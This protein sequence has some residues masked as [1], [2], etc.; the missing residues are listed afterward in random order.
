[1][2]VW[3]LS[4]AGVSACGLGL[5]VMGKHIETKKLF[6]LAVSA[7]LL[8]APVFLSPVTNFTKN[9][10]WVFVLTF[11]L[12]RI[13]KY[14]FFVCTGA[15]MIGYSFVAILEYLTTFF[16]AVSP[17]WA[18][19]ALLASPGA[20]IGAV[21]AVIGQ[22]LLSQ[23]PAR[24]RF[25]D[26]TRV[27][28]REQLRA[29]K[30]VPLAQLFT[31]FLVVSVLLA[32]AR[33]QMLEFTMFLQVLLGR[34]L[35]FVLVAPILLCAYF[36]ERYFAARRTSVTPL[37]L[38]DFVLIVPVIL[39]VLVYTGGPASPWKVL[40]IPFVI[41]NAL[42]KN[43]AFGIAGIAVAA[44]IL[45]SLNVIQSGYG[46]F[47][48]GLDLVFL[49]SFFFVFVV[50]RSFITAENKLNAEIESARRNLLASISHDLRTPITLLQGY[51]EALLDKVDI[52]P[53]KGARYLQLI[54]NRTNSLKNL[55]RDLAELVQLETR[56]T[57]LNFSRV[58]V[59]ELL[60]QVY[61]HYE[62][63]VSSKGILLKMDS[64]QADGVRIKADPE[65]LDRVFANLIYN[66]IN[67]T[68]AGGVITVGARTDFAADEVLF[69]VSDTGAGVS[70]EE[71]PKIFEKFYRGTGSKHPVKGSGL[72][73]AISKEIVEYHSGRVWAES[74]ENRGS[75]FFF[76]LPITG[77]KVR[78][79]VKQSPVSV[80][81]MGPPAQMISAFIVLVA[82]FSSG[83]CFVPPSPAVPAFLGIAALSLF[84][85]LAARQK[86]D[87]ATTRMGLLWFAADIII[88]APLIFHVIISTGSSSS[89][90][91]VLFIPFIITNTM[92]PEKICG[93]AG[94]A[95][96]TA[97]LLLSG[98]TSL[99][100]GP[101]WFIEQDLAYIS[102]FTVTHV[103]VRHF[104]SVENSLNREL[105]DSRRT[106]LTGV[107]FELQAPMN[108]I[109]ES[110][111]GLMDRGHKEAGERRAA[112]LAV[113]DQ[114][115]R[116]TRMVED[117]FELV[118]LESRRSVLNLMHFP[119]PEL[120]ARVAR[121]HKRKSGD[122]D[123]ALELTVPDGFPADQI[124]IQAD[125]DRLGEVLD[126]LMT[127]AGV[128]DA[129]KIGFTLD[130]T[131]QEVLFRIFKSHYRTAAAS[132]DKRTISASG[133][134]SGRLRFLI[135]EQIIHLHGG[136]FLNHETPDSENGFSFTL[137][138]AT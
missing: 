107:A 103:I 121:K 6:S 85:A 53:E 22:K 47:P 16:V 119:L 118:Q 138:V 28:D 110:V 57:S 15:V 17:T 68:P 83:A 97:A 62:H 72:G 36:T 136:R 95:T 125:P 113:Q 49:V 23:K 39:F 127:A 1:M 37:D 106:L 32:T 18:I 69:Y 24:K 40:L 42:K 14:S 86:K 134:A 76:A 131:G 55:A 93:L 2:L 30:A 129:V 100:T 102:L 115:K 75:S 132:D 122:K 9:Y 64:P 46:A 43:T 116:L 70:K 10:L 38:V 105:A 58:S 52:N 19:R 31:A 92:K 56:K 54:L 112:L 74:E 120:A 27:S 34:F 29:L 88:L 7:S 65:R 73:L 111:G 109:S 87:I 8:T 126:Y 67:H 25:E 94:L 101:G 13:K 20:L 35:I 66:A 80:S 60:G 77:A 99:Q 123:L 50:I 90:W 41:I 130:Y 133:D 81:G 5:F 137:P 84:A 117:L 135:A 61:V 78:E 98:A 108:V 33:P 124:M 59:S 82:F 79:N 91:K 21:L 11:L 26:F 48:P 71:L 96:A 4:V 89:P 45:F 12:Y 51:T 114:V 104:M 128:E 63:D 44:G 3:L